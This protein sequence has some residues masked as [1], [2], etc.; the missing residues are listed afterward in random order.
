MNFTETE[1]M[2]IET[3]STLVVARHLGMKAIKM[4]SSEWGVGDENALKLY[5]HDGLINQ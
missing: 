4:T 1:G 5:S 3:D 2:F